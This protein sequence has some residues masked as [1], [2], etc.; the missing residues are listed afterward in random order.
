MCFRLVLPPFALSLSTCAKG[1]TVERDWGS[2][3]HTPAHLQ[4]PGARIPE[5]Y[6]VETAA[7]AGG[8]TRSAGGSAGG[9]AAETAASLLLKLRI[10]FWLKDFRGFFIFGQPDFL[11]DFVAGLFLSVKVRRG[12]R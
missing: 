11:L 6:A 10:G 9:T 1:Q 2:H 7:E 4:G 8:E 5:N 12:R 3:C